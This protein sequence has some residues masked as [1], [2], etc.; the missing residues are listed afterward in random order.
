MKR[1]HRVVIAFLVTL[2]MVFAN[3]TMA[4][5]NPVI[6]ENIDQGEMVAPVEEQLEEDQELF[7]PSGEEGISEELE[8]PEED[9][10]EM[11]FLPTVFL[12]KKGGGTAIHLKNN[13]AEGI[14]G[15]VV[16]FDDGNS[17]TLVKGNGNNWEASDQGMRVLDHI[18]KLTVTFEDTGD[19]DYIY[20]QDF[21]P[22][23]GKVKEPVEHSAEGQGSGT[24]NLWINKVKTIDPEQPGIS[25][26]K[27]VS[28][29]AVASKDAI[30]VYTFTV[31]NDGEKDLTNVVLTDPLLGALSIE[32]G[33][34][35]QGAE[36]T[37]SVAFDLG[38][39]DSTS[40]L[41]DTFTN[42]AEVV[43]TAGD[44]NV[45]D[46]D[47]A[48]VTFEP[49]DVN[50]VSQAAISLIK[51]VSPAAVNNRGA[52]VTYTFTIT[53]TGELDLHGVW[54]QDTL[55]GQPN[56]PIGNLAA[57]ETTTVAIDFNLSLLGTGGHGNWAG[58]T[59]T[60]TAT[61]TGYNPTEEPITATDTAVVTYNGGGGGGNPGDGE[62]PGGG[63]DPGGSGNT[64]PGGD[65]TT[66][67]IP[68]EEVPAGPAPEKGSEVVILEEAIP[69]GT[70]PQ[71]GGFD[72]LLLY[73]LGALVTGSGIVL[74]RRE[75]Q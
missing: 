65:D 40:W 56:H 12:Q 3:G 45:E 20:P 9:L 25:L 28:P 11:D 2:L 48:I 29:A 62:E 30:V 63:G 32:I 43:G 57:G 75:E 10:E 71:T 21:G 6:D 33:N 16:W 51:E 68:D 54:L 22:R 50:P 69:A 52:T 55:I 58:D 41:E 7:D 70:L 64:D 36:Y 14:I 37:T 17:I 24:I 53:N 8:A 13:S 23:G 72:A 15:A 5:A 42:I 46:I 19:V 49:P 1:K 18:T 31:I 66:V 35:A 26:I 44:E 74:R 61:V 59:F 67:N 60:N 34:L 4:F 47:E 73:G 27:T 39:L 38:N